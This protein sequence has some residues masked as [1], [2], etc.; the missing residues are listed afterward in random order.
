MIN[1]PTLEITNNPISIIVDTNE[2]LPIEK[3][4]FFSRYRIKTSNVLFLKFQFKEE[5]DQNYFLTTFPATWD[6]EKEQFLLG[7]FKEKQIIQIE[8]CKKLIF[9][10][11]VPFQIDW[12]SKSQVK[13]LII[14]SYIANLP[15]SI[16]NIIIKPQGRLKDKKKLNR[17]SLTCIIQLTNL[18]P[19]GSFIGSI[20]YQFTP[21]NSIINSDWGKKSDYDTKFIQKYTLEQKY[22]RF[23]EEFE[24]IIQPLNEIIDICKI[25]KEVYT[26][27]KNLITIEYLDYR[28]GVLNLLRE[29]RGDCDE[30]TDLM[31]VLLRKMGFPVRRVTGMIYEFTSKQITLHAWP[32]IY[33]PKYNKWVVIDAAMNYFGFQSLTVI[34]LKIEGTNVLPN[35]LEVNFVDQSQKISLDMQ[36][37]DIV[38]TPSFIP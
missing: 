38:I 25:A 16:N 19:N 30:F 23:P 29:M 6:G 7:E 3:N 24:K 9:D 22:L 18:K 1:T 5:F 32:E 26:I 21:K 13:G 4:Q 12:Q 15:E 2:I 27:A 8:I 31:V 14:K 34:P 33:S 37:L 20:Q 36:L 10:V 28:K 17:D 11:I 35:Q